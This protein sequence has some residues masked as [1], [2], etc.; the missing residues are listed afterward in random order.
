MRRGTAKRVGGTRS[1]ARAHDDGDEP[2]SDDRVCHGVIFFWLFRLKRGIHVHISVIGVKGFREP[3]LPCPDY[4][5]SSW[6]RAAAWS[7]SSGS[8]GLAHLSPRKKAPA[9]ST[10]SGKTALAVVLRAA[11]SFNAL[12]RAESPSGK[13]GSEANHSQ[14]QRC[15]EEED[16]QKTAF[17][18]QG[19]LCVHQIP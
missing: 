16:S 14:H 7:S 13:Q 12:L 6:G 17:N 10:L 19:V 5:T 18:H 9:Q 11:R 3:R 4:R 1:C 2:A 8:D 15:R